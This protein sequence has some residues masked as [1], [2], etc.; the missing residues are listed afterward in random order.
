MDN[1]ETPLSK[2][3]KGSCCRREKIHQKPN[4]SQA[5]PDVNSGV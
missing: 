4:L 1:G 3:K 2:R 5:I